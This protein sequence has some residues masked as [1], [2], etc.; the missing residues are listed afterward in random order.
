MRFCFRI[1]QA[2]TS[3]IARSSNNY[4][5]DDNKGL[6]LKVLVI[7][8]VGIVGLYGTDVFSTFN[9][10]ATTVKTFSTGQQQ[11]GKAG[12][13]TNLKEGSENRGAMTRLTRREINEKLQQVPVFFATPKSSNKAIFVEGGTGLIFTTKEEADNY[14]V[15]KP[16]LEV[17]ATRSRCHTWQSEMASTCCL[18]QLMAGCGSIA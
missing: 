11:Q 9:Q 5:D 18:W 4:G 13:M 12:Q 15:G 8:F 16:D 7:G 10:A 17:S 1:D 3:I 2:P 14:I 6:S